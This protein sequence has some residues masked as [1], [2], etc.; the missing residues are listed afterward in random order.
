MHVRSNGI[1]AIKSKKETKL[2]AAR[3]HQRHADRFH[4][5]ARRHGRALRRNHVRPMG[6]A[7]L[8]RQRHQPRRR[9]L[10]SSMTV[11]PKP[12]AENVGTAASAVQAAPRPMRLTQP[13]PAEK[14]STSPKRHAHPLSNPKTDTASALLPTNTAYQPRRQRRHQHQKPPS[15]SAK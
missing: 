10:R 7:G 1:N 9:R 8:R 12:E 14:P 5:L 6:R 15:V 2:V 4:R 3:H 13:S 11:T